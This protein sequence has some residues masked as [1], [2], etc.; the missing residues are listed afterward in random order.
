MD[1][2][3]QPMPLVCIVGETASGKSALGLRL[4]RQFNGEIICADS[5]TVRKGVDI[6]SAKPTTAEQALVPHHLLDV[7]EPCESF[8]AAQFKELT[9]RAIKDIQGRGKLP[10]L[11]GG[12][13]L[14][15]DSVLF[16]YE[17][18]AV[19]DENLRAELNELELPELQTRAEQLGLDLSSV[20]TR[21][22]RRVIRLIE[23]K[24]VRAERQPLRT[25][26]VVLG[27]QIER[28]VLKQRI[29][30]RVDKMMEAGL[31]AEVRG[32]VKRSGWD[33]EALKGV[34]YAQWQ[35]YFLGAKSLTETRQEI[36]KATTNL[37]KR[38]RTWFK[39]NKSIHW[40]SNPLEWLEIVELVTTNLNT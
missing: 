23:T 21:N 40:L 11:V 13:G 34:G 35:E 37:A 6:G 32:L 36:I 3:T 31:E 22:K 19:G 16:D 24:G 33:C 9:E 20:D 10:I 26:T 18:R 7:V 29:A 14:Y 30:K 4:A 28:D 15:V 2:A 39:R 38:Q 27:L 1:T 25:N 5:M 17:F 8:T 12:T